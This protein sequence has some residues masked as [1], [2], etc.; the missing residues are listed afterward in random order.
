ELKVGVVLECEQIE[1]TRLLKSQIKV[2]EQVKQIVSGI[3]NFYTPQQMQ[4]KKVIVVTNLKPVKL[5]GV[6]SEGMILAASNGKGK[7]ENLAIVTVDLD[8][9]DGSM[10]R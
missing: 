3:A 9:A 7:G 4:G 2:G 10:V 1:G 5:R 8:I 6:L